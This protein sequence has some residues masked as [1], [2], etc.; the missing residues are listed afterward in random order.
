MALGQS[1]RAL[2]VGSAMIDTIAII[3]SELIEHLTLRNAETSFLL[4]EAG[5]KTEALDV[6]THSGGGGLNVAVA[7]ARLGIE[8]AAL[9]KLGDDERADTICHQ[10]AAE[11]VAMDWVVRDGRQP[12]G[13]AVHLSSH[14]RDAAIFTF[15]G[16]NTLLV[17]EDLDERAFDVDLVYVSS[18]SEGSADCFPTVVDMARTKGAMVAANPGIRQLS[19]RAG[20]FLD[21]LNKIDLLTLN[22]VEADT[23]VPGLSSQP[24]V[25][26]ARIDP[27][28]G[29]DAP[30]LVVRGFASDGFML[31]FAAF[32]DGILQLGPKYVVVT[33]GT[34]GAFV[35][36]RDK[37]IHCPIVPTDV[38]GTAGAGDAFAAT[39]AGYLALGCPLEESVHAAAI[40]AG[41]VV[42]LIDAQ[43]GLL[44]RVEID[45]RA[46]AMSKDIDVTTWRLG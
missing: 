40:N 45:T 25:S 15:R 20:A 46:V 6:S 9:V 21:C 10:L 23:L 2:A 42:T 1:I 27:K 3:A 12:T 16:A 7:L 43:G 41:S 22:R 14:D 30:A 44:N 28:P 33:D 17:K 19:T 35:A 29:R 26:A 8:T 39:L 11:G 32:F 31:P 24:A 18:L 5:R 38:A 36:M 34:A 4:M 37:V 13:A